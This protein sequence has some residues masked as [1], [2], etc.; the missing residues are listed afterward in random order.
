MKE[1]RSHNTESKNSKKVIISVI[2]MN[3]EHKMRV[4]RLPI[5]SLL[6][7]RRL[8]TLASLFLVLVTAAYHTNL[9]PSSTIYTLYICDYMSNIMCTVL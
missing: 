6:F 1:K 4:C 9:C 2:L 8:H 7:T 5:D 3:S